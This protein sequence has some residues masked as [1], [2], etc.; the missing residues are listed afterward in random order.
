MALLEKL[1][2]SDDSLVLRKGCTNPNATNYDPAAT[3]DDGSCILGE[4]LSLSYEPIVNQ[5]Q[6]TVNANLSSCDVYVNG[7]KADTNENGITPTSLYYTELELLTPKEIT[8]RKSGF[9]STDKYRIS[10]KTIFVEKTTTFSL[11]VK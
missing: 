1:I 8:V 7:N 6:F 3:V 9:E 4:Q 11:D 2:L 5:Y 10:T